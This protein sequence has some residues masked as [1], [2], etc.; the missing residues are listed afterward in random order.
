[1]RSR[2]SAYALGNARYVLDT[3]HPDTRPATLD[4]RDGTRYLGL[5]V[6]GAAGPFV[7]FTAQLRLPGGER[8]ALREN[9]E[10]VQLEGRWVYLDGVTADADPDAG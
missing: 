6:R 4:L 10:F 9:S 2:Y 5:R 8:Y 1:M 3:W 7:E